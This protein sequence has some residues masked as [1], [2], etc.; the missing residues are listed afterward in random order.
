LNVSTFS[1]PF[2]IAKYLEGVDIYR[3]PLIIDANSSLQTNAN[4]MVFSGLNYIVIGRI[5]DQWL[6][7]PVYLSDQELTYYI[8]TLR[9]NS[10]TLNVVLN[11][12][13]DYLIYLI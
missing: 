6:G 9:W 7:T 5:I 10:P 4:R 8:G 13:K 12:N 11:N 3:L 1:F 2:S